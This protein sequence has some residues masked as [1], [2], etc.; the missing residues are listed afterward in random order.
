MFGVRVQLHLGQMANFA[1][2]TCIPAF[3]ASDYIDQRQEW[4]TGLN[5]VAILETQ[6]SQRLLVVVTHSPRH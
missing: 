5:R 1:D 4:P 6:D 2:E 3:A